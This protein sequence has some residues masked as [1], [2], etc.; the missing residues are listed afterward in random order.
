MVIDSSALIAILLGEAQAPALAVAI[1][2]DPKRLVSA[3]TALETSVVIENRK[4][5]IGGREFD[6]LLH[7]CGAVVVAMTADHFNLARE[8]YSSYGKGRHPAGLNLGD[9]CTYALA[10]YTGEPLL[11]VGDDFA[12]TDLKLVSY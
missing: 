5:L 3:Y 4:G 11:F 10:R 2:A 12:K 9:C 6:L 7:K 1:A 8:A